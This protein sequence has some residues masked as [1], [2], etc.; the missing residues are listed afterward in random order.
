MF[1]LLAL[2]TAAQASRPTDGVGTYSFDQTDVV[3]SV[4]GP[5]GMVRVHYSV[6]GPNQ[7]RLE[8]VDKD[9]VPDFAW[10]VAVTAEDVLAVYNSSGFRAP[11]T[12]L[13]MGLSGLGGSDAFDFYLV[14]F[15]G[16][17]DGQFGVDTCSGDVCS[18]YMMMDNDISGYGYGSLAA[19]ID[20]LTSHE[21]FHGVQFAYNAD[22]PG[23]VSEGTA[24]WGEYHYDPGSED[25]LAWCDRLLEE[26][27]R[28]IDSPP[29]G[30]FTGW[31]YGTGLFFSF[32]DL[33]LGPQALVSFQEQLAL[34]GGEAELEALLA[35]LELSGA[36]LEDL[37]IEFATWN[38][39]TGDHAGAMDSYPFAAELTE[40]QA[41]QEG[42]DLYD[43]DRVY[44][45]ATV[46]VRVDHP[47]GPLWMGIPDDATG[48]YV[49]V[50]PGEA[51]GPI[52]PS[53]ATWWPQGEGQVT[54]LGEFDAGSLWV[55]MTQP[56]LADSSIAIDYCLG[57]EANLAQCGLSADAEPTPV[58]EEPAGCACTSSPRRGIPLLWALPLLALAL[59]RRRA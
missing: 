18:G 28:S 56:A 22:Q 27:E 19:A 59:G 11:L 51:D 38:L 8:D 23:W 12:E 35:T 33:K 39:A 44:P 7:T 20:T 1:V 9:G 37:W 41:R 45:L 52:G 40:V 36:S 10:Q 58:E 32:L 21:L 6:E 2:T 46:Y 48:L 15:A 34:K 24:M 54:T 13:E 55:L 26:P 5:G 16:T 53:A 47:G 14:D 3:E 49:A 30:A 4:D 57:S 25:F 43:D 50:H 31:E 29:A 17:G 42:Q